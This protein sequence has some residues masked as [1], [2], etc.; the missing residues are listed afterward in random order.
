[1]QVYT[2]SDHNKQMY[3]KELQINITAY[4]YRAMKYGT[5]SHILS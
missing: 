1:M 4:T 3:D 5:A 2:S